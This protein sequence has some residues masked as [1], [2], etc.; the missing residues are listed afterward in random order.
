MSGGLAPDVHAERHT[1][2]VATH[3]DTPTPLGAHV[4]DF[5]PFL[6][7]ALA[8]RSRLGST[9][10]APTLERGHVVPSLAWGVGCCTERQHPRRLGLHVGRCSRLKRAALNLAASLAQS[11]AS[12]A[13]S[14]ASPGGGCL[15]QRYLSASPLC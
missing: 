5:R 2:A 3:A 7:T 15:A 1:D 12:L 10:T 9:A 4:A 8:P 14:V 11:V 6:P 13:Q